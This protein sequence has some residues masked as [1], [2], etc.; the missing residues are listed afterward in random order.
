MNPKTGERKPPLGVSVFVLN[1]NHHLHLNRSNGHLR[2]SHTEKFFPLPNQLQKTANDSESKSAKRAVFLHFFLFSLVMNQGTDSHFFQSS[3]IF[4]NGQCK[5][6]LSF[7]FFCTKQVIKIDQDGSFQ[8]LNTT[9]NDTRLPLM[10]E[11]NSFVS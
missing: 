3:N 8:G 7:I 5:L 4:S 1:V 9:S 6:C 2:H 11:P 10:E